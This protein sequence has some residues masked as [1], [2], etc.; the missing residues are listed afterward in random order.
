MLF[1]NKI[2]INLAQYFKNRM[3][4]IY[5]DAMLIFFFFLFCGGI[6]CAQDK[7]R[8]QIP[9]TEV[10]QNYLSETNEYAVLFNGKTEAPYDRLYQ[11]QPY[12]ETFVFVKGTLCYNNV[13]Y[14][15]INMRLDLYRDELSV[16]SPNRPFPVVLDIKKFNYAILNGNMII[17]STNESNTG[18]KYMLLIK[19]G[20]YPVTKQYRV[21][22]N[23]DV[24]QLEIKRSFRFQERY[25]ITINGITY[26]IKN[27][28]TL[29]NL[30]PDRKKELN[31]FA[32]QHKLSFKSQQFGQSIVALVNHYENPTR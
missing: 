31:E 12:F 32:K 1:D 22:I 11:N 30:F 6:I 23:E 7:G 15:N 16:Y 3:K 17:A 4:R 2:M 5:T 14:Q 9:P 21:T 19:E 10:I 20:L 28:N 18:F 8:T 25:H 29:L 24:S 13:V 26:Q 27:K